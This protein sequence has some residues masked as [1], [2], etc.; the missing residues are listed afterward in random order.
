MR[1]ERWKSLSWSESHAAWHS[2]QKTRL[3]A[4]SVIA[5]PGGNIG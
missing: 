3:I 5:I 2:G 4:P 1:D